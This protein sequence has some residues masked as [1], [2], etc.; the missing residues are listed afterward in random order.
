MVSGCSVDSGLEDS[1][2][3][4]IRSDTGMRSNAHLQFALLSAPD[5]A[6]VV[7][8]GAPSGDP[9]F[10]TSCLQCQL[11]LWS[12]LP[13]AHADELAQW[14][15][16]WGSKEGRCSEYRSPW[17]GGPLGLSWCKRWARQPKIWQRMFPC[18]RT[19]WR[20]AYACRSGWWSPDLSCRHDVYKLTV[21][22]RVDEDQCTHVV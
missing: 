12:R 18:C 10:R 1:G 17:Y 8:S 15:G 4:A 2:F 5:R 19:K 3:G 22:N 16:G 7:I 6:A 20:N 9:S 14:R 11:Y 13:N 21:K